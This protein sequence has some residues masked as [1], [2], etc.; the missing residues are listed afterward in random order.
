MEKLTKRLSTIKMFNIYKGLL[1]NTQQEI[2]FDYLCLDLSITEISEN[3]NISRSAVEDAIKKGT[4]K[5]EEI[6]EAVSMYK[7]MKPIKE[8]IEALIEISKDEEQI[9]LLNEILGDLD[10][11]I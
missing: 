11:G 6:E 9:K 10:D 8:K 1:S 4:H 2:L 3:R 5:L 7:K